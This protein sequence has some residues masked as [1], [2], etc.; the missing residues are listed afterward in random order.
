MNIEN[1]LKD[2]TRAFHEQHDLPPLDDVAASEE[3]HEQV[4]RARS[5]VAVSCGGSCQV[6]EFCMPIRLTHTETR[7]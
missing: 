7:G 2:I 1:V 4:V 3:A 6:I 5:Y